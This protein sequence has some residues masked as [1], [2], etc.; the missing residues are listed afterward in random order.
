M[1]WLAGDL[2]SGIVEP[3]TLV[4]STACTPPTPS[5][6][7][8]RAR[9]V[10][11][12]EHRT[13]GHR[14]YLVQERAAILEVG[15]SRLRSRFTER[16]HPA[17]DHS[18]S[19]WLGACVTFV[20]PSRCVRPLSE[21]T[22]QPSV[23]QERRH[24]GLSALSLSPKEEG[25]SAPQLQRLS[26]RVHSSVQLVACAAQRSI[27]RVRL[28]MGSFMYIMERVGGQE[29]G[30]RALQAVANLGCTAPPLQT[31]E[32]P[33]QW[34]T[35]PCQQ[36]GAGEVRGFGFALWRQHRRAAHGRCLGCAR[37]CWQQGRGCEG[38]AG[39]DVRRS[40]AR[41]RRERRCVRGRCGE[42]VW[43]RRR[44]GGTSPTRNS[45]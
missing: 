8:R 4:S 32:S 29:A 35:W 3:N 33:R 21:S 31:A 5:L 7:T 15:A 19:A 34:W 22:G 45:I 38:R 25:G 10:H 40:G 11:A 2:T 18:V 44:T 36:H 6:S 27:G 12:V 39:L 1:L 14:S 20:R 26:Q 24:H 23:E 37:T 41:R 9:P 30:A 13:M 16:L 28:V 42:R 43:G 17:S